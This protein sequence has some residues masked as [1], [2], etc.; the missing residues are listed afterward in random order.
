MGR[1]NR[2]EAPPLHPG[3]AT[4][5]DRGVVGNALGGSFCPG[6][7]V[8][9]I[10]RNPAIFAGPYRL[11]QA[12]SPTPGALSHPANLAG[13]TNAGNAASLSAGLEP[14][15]IGKYDAVPWQSDFNECSTQPIDVTYEQWNAIDPA[16]TGDPVKSIVQNTY[17]WPAHRPM[18][19]PLPGAGMVPWSPTAQTNAG[20]LQMVTEWSN[21]GFLT[22]DPNNPP[23]V[24]N[25]GLGGFILTQ[26]QTHG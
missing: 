23:S 24:T 7:E 5:L 10:V 8:C 16:S 13:D 12:A 4:A 9:W 20:D 21:L 19:V 2:C 18:N 14:G 3:E 6:A 17:W 26:F 11:R 15:D 22:P 25:A 1:N